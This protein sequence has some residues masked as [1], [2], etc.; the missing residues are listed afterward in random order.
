MLQYNVPGGKK[1]RGLAVVASY[2]MLVGDDLKPEDLFLAQV[3]G[4]CVEMVGISHEDSRC[5]VFSKIG[6]LT[7][8]LIF[9]IKNSCKRG[10]WLMTISWMRQ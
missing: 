3:G 9:M 5:N 4:W 1:N 6:V 8:T 10:S 7:L 2:K